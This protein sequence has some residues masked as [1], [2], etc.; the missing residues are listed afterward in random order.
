MLQGLFSECRPFIGGCAAGALLFNLQSNSSGGDHLRRVQSVRCLQIGR[1]GRRSGDLWHRYYGISRLECWPFMGGCAAGALLFNLQSNSSG[2]DHLRRVQSVR[3]LQ[4]GRIGRRSGD[5]WHRY[6]VISR[7]ECWPFMGGCAAG[8]L[9]FNLQ[10]HSSGG[11]QLR[12][13]QSVRWLQI[14]RIGR[15]SGDLWHRYY[16]ITRLLTV[17]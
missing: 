3:W 8:A 2:G 14:G 15:R 6:Y 5:L 16:V 7:L 17:S 12:R 10:S 9:L 4:I 11:D 1:I 13:A